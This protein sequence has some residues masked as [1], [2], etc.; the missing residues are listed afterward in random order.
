LDA[1]IRKKL[2]VLTHVESLITRGFT[3]LARAAQYSI[4]TKEASLSQEKI[5][6]VQDRVLE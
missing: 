3:T 6:E 5:K 4:R 1:E 2:S